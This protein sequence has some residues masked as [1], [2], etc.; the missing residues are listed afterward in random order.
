MNDQ[1]QDKIKIALVDIVSSR[2]GVD[3]SLTSNFSKLLL[4][5]NAKFTIHESLKS[6]ELLNPSEGIIEYRSS[7]D[8]ILTLSKIR[9]TQVVINGSVIFF[10]ELRPQSLSLY[11]DVLL[12]QFRDLTIIFSDGSVANYSNSQKAL[13][14][15]IP[16]YNVEKQLPDLLESLV[17]VMSFPLEVIFVDDGSTDHS[18]AL[19]S[20][21]VEQHTNSIL[22]HKMNGGCA[23]ARNHGMR[24]AT[25]K[26][27]MFVDGD[28]IVDSAGLLKS[29]VEISSYSPDIA[30]GKYSTFTNS[31]IE[32]REVDIYEW[33]AIVPT[34][35]SAK[36][37][38]HGQP[39][40]WRCFYRRDFLANND[41]DFLEVDRFDDLP[42]WFQT[43]ILA[44]DVLVLR[45]NLYFW[46]LGREGQTMGAT[47]NRLFVHFEIF[48]HLNEW[49]SSRP[50]SFFRSLWQ[51]KI[52]TH[53]W[54]LGR[55][56]PKFRKEYKRKVKMDFWGKN[57]RIGVIELLWALKTLKSRRNLQT[58]LSA[59]RILF[60]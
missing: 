33:L 13:S 37:L 18:H 20:N 5:L 3:W 56:E 12:L 27:I 59:L 49:V 29:I 39:S 4:G 43:S 21:W 16:V 34:T 2:Y 15:V 23:T 11:F 48:H 50:R 36:T 6:W 55:L 35:V 19:I 25:G 51:T 40:I 26:Y 14:V 30:V 41:L 8:L 38:I 32:S 58:C 7:L 9:S 42:F 46:R 22:V 54:A 47:D 44:E 52:D 17:P 31:I 45:D 53:L 60:F 28:D 24:L 10:T 1:I 57:R